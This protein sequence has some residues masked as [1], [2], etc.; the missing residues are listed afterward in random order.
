MTAIAQKLDRKLESWDAMKA[1]QVE[2]LVEEIIDLADNDSL[3]IS[4][5]R[6]VTQDVL[7]LIDES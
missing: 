4:A 7:D 6:Q 3:D 2:K 1:A 5:S